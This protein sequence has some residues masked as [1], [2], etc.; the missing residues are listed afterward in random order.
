MGE[1]LLAFHLV[2]HIGQSVALRIEVRR[3]DLLDISGEDHLGALSG[4]GDDR[5]DLVR[6]EVLRLVDNAESL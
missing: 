3:V 5:L 4:T 6:R 1:Q 2:D